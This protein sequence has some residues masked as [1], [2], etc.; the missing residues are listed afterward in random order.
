MITR[1]QLRKSSDNSMLRLF[2]KLNRVSI[3]LFH[4]NRRYILPTLK[5]TTG[6]WMEPKY[7]GLIF[8]SCPSSS[9][10]L[11]YKIDKKEECA[12]LYWYIKVEKRKTI[13]VQDKRCI[14]SWWYWSQTQTSSQQGALTVLYDTTKILWT[15]LRNACAL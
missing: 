5:A 1:V 15:W 13:Y 11:A 10:G 8:A 12:L 6:I 9:L 7:K 4:D 14:I 3:Q 2:D